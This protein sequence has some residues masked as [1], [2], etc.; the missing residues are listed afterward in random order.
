M[1][2]L[3]LFPAKSNCTVSFRSMKI[4]LTADKNP[5]N[6]AYRLKDA[7]K[8][9]KE[10]FMFKMKVELEECSVGYIT[11]NCSQNAERLHL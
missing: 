1:T 7:S 6:V 2:L 4:P 3:T 8:L 5:Q 9:L 11:G 10:N